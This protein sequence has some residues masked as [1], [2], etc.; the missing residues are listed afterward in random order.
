MAKFK[1]VEVILYQVQDTEDY[2]GTSAII[3]RCNNGRTND[4]YADRKVSN[5]F[6]SQKTAERQAEI[7]NR[8]YD[9]GVKNGVKNG[10][11]VEAEKY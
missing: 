2:Y 9:A 11:K 8:V 1:V 5:M 3:E 6:D 10:S 7:L 4:S